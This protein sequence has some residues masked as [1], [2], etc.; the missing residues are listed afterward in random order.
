MFIRY[1]PLAVSDRRESR[2]EDRDLTG[3]EFLFFGDVESEYRKEG[4]EGVR[5]DLGMEAGRMNKAVWDEASRSIRDGRLAGIFVSRTATFD[6]PR[7][8]GY[9]SNARTT[10]R[11]LPISCLVTSRLRACIMN[12]EPSHHS[13]RLN[14]MITFPE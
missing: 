5:S 1:D 11:D 8:M 14:R 4:E 13:S 9:R 6:R 12:Y 10:R 7:L 2:A 3:R